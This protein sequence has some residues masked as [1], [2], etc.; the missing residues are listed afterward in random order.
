MLK[1]EL[2]VE[3]AELKA[4]VGEL[5]ARTA[6]AGVPVD[7]GEALVSMTSGSGRTVAYCS[8]RRKGFNVVVTNPDGT[9]EARKVTGLTEAHQVM[10]ELYVIG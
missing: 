9:Q 10:S 1:A 4:R 3:N 5:E 2:E 6:T 7:Y 8:H